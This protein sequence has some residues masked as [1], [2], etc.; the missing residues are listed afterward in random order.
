MV[1]GPLPGL[2]LLDDLEEDER[3]ARDHRFHAVRAHLLEMAGEREA[4]LLSF[5][6]A[7]DMA[8]SFPVQRYLNAKAAPLRGDE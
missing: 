7:A 8:M 5:E 4:A 3:V 6:E 1:D 2:A